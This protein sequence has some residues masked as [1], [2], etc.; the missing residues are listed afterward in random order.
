M[1]IMLIGI[2]VSFFSG[3]VTIFSIGAFFINFG[4]R[5][6]YN[7]AVLTLAEVSS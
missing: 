3:N 7:A 6:F 5:G 1:V 4:F 2:V